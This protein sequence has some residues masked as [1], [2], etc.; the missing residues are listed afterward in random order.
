ME[1]GDAAPGQPFGRRAHREG[2]RARPP[3]QR[4][5]LTLA[6][7][8]RGP[9]GGPEWC[10]PAFARAGRT[11]LNS[12][13]EISPLVTAWPFT[14]ATGADIVATGRYQWSHSSQGGG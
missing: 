13:T 9:H 3:D 8:S 12:F 10:T 2:L 5:G 1:Q 6:C 11:R 4:T 7:W 14:A